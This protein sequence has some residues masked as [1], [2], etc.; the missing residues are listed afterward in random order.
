MVILGFA[1]SYGNF[2]LTDNAISELKDFIR[3]GQCNV[4]S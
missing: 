2:D 4:H 3:I 1:D